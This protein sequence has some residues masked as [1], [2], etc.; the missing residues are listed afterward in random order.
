MNYLN[1]QELSQ[2]RQ[3]CKNWRAFIDREPDLWKP[4]TNG[5]PSEGLFNAMTVLM[6]KEK[7]SALFFI[8]IFE[9]ENPEMEIDWE[10]VQKQRLATK[11]NWM[12][13]TAHLIKCSGHKER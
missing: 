10:K 9:I 4:K 3:V 5:N 13:G 11:R 1:L 8:I 7:S 2:A 6:K 12:T